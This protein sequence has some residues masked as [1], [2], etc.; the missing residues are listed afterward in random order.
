MAEKIPQG[1][2]TAV[3]TPLRK[4]GQKSNVQRPTLR[5][6]ATECE[7]DVEGLR[8]LLMEV[9]KTAV[10]INSGAEGTLLSTEIRN[11][12]IEE[13]MKVINGDTELIIG[14]TGNS[15][16]ET[17]ENIK[18][19]EDCRKELRYTGKIFLFDCPLWYHSNRGLPANYEKLTQFTS[20][21]IILSNNPGLISKPVRN[22]SLN[23][24][25]LRKTLKRHNI[26]TNVFKKLSQNV[27]I[28]GLEHSGDLRRSLNYMRAG[29]NRAD[30][31][32]YDGNELNFL[33]NPSS[34]GV[35]SIGANIL[36]EYWEEVVNSSLQPDDSRK[37]DPEYCKDL[38]KKRE[39]IKKLILC[40]RANPVALV[41][42][43]L[44]CTG[45]INSDTVAE[46]LKE[47][48]SE[49]KAKIC[50]FLEASYKTQDVSAE[51]ITK[52]L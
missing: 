1:L 8:K 29:R 45:V 27:R 36:H 9:K 16:E 37:E 30:F 46:A 21:P 24:S 32:F 17:L 43:G 13:A 49:E 41:K 5:V 31:G 6:G 52:S 14:I 40:Y 3:V 50:K 23:G 44:K 51:E 12:L 34:S 10:L 2:I 20:L 42:A 15:A 48:S 47:A 19:V 22:K 11:K 18:V 38:W 28:V 4:Y 35:I 39:M 26:R 25:N 7:L 33:N